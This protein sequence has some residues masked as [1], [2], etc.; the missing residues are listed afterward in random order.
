MMEDKNWLQIK[1][2]LDDGMDKKK[3]LGIKWNR[4]KKCF[5]VDFDIL[6]PKFYIYVL[7]GVCV[8]LAVQ[9]LVFIAG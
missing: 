9:S 5:D 3:W 1:W 8:A 6:M 4:D 7:I 2:V